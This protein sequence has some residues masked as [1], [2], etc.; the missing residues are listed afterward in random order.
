MGS[1]A[2]PTTVAQKRNVRTAAASGFFGTTLEYYDFLI[3]GTAAALFFGKVFF[4]DPSLG[5]LLALGT[6]GVAYVARP[7]GAVMWGHLG[8]KFGR[9]KVLLAILLTMGVATFLVG[10]IPGY[11]SIGA[12]SPVLLVVLRIVQG[13]SAGGEQTGSAL[14]AFEHAPDRRR[15]FYTSWTQSGSQFGN[16]VASVV[17]LPL[18]VLLPKEAMLAWGW[19]IPFWLSALIIALTFVL[20]RKLAEPEVGKRPGQDAAT[21]TVPLVEV[22]RDHWRAVLRVVVGGLCISPA[23]LV[24]VFGLSYGT[25]VIGLSRSPMLVLVAGSALGMGITIPFFAILSDRIGRKP[26]FLIGLIGCMALIPV[27]LGAVHAGN[28]TVI[29]LAGFALMDIFLAM[30]TAI[31]LAT[32]LEMFPSHLRFSGTA[33]GFM[34]G[35]VLTGLLPAIAQSF[36]QGDPGNWGPVALLF[37]G[38]LAAAG[39][40]LLAGP[41][42]YRVPT[43][44]LGLGRAAAPADRENMKKSGVS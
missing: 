3:Y 31:I 34:L 22:F 33:V 6:F 9:K 19:R 32:F 14:I 1:T 42:T 39:I 40:A 28:W 27:W 43:R 41:E 2:A 7:F 24:Y 18:T 4:P 44:A 35:I 20:R 37:A 10:C 29:F 16:F 25:N 13:L 21:A 26:V 30:P 36:V 15:A 5:T 17:F 12:A 11:A 23:G 8:D 38:L